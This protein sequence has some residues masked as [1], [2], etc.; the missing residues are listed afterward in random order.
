MQISGGWTGPE[1]SP[2]LTETSWADWNRDSDGGRHKQPEPRPGSWS[3]RRD[4][5]LDLSKLH[6]YSPEFVAA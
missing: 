3:L 6:N 1:G 4:A 5:G 2:F